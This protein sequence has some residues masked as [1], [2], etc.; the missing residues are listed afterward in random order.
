MAHPP[1]L[2]AAGNFGQTAAMAPTSQRPLDHCV[3]PVASLASA[4]TRLAALGFNVAPEGVHPFGTANACVYFADGTFLEPLAQADARAEAE[5]A[6]AGNVFAAR[7]IEHRGGHGDDGFSAVVF[8]TADAAADHGRFVRAGISAGPVLDFSR[9]FVGADGRRDE[10]GFRLAFAADPQ[11][12]GC[13]FFTCQRIGVP[14]VD[15]AALQVHANGVVG[16][17]SVVLAATDPDRFTRLL[18]EVAGDAGPAGSAIEL[19]AKERFRERF[20][21]VP[22][23]DPAAGAI[24]FTVTDM[25]AASALLAAGNVDAEVR[26]GLTIVHPV[27]GQGAVFAFEEQ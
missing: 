23:G 2:E 1:Q 20:G 18:A 5:A 11:G 26:D 6:N 3:L 7:D 4:R 8:G 16:I 25:A 14:K 22:A 9:D 15:R 21:T 27:P 13:F 19:L 17:R 12:P 10:A 24:V